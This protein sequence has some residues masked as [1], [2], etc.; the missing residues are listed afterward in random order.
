MNSTA[1]TVAMI[2]AWVGEQDPKATPG[3][4]DVPKK[5]AGGG[6]EP[7]GSPTTLSR[8]LKILKE[9]LRQFERSN[10]MKDPVLREKG[11]ALLDVILDLQDDLA[12]ARKNYAR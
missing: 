9:E 3:G 7:G 6:I 1:I 2:T 11:K 8:R 10:D 4:C 12:D 5:A